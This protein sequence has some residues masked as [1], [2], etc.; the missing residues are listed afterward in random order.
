VEI[1]YWLFEDANVPM[2]MVRTLSVKLAIVIGDS[3][4]QL[5][6]WWGGTFNP[7][8]LSFEMAMECFSCGWAPS[9]ML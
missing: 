5:L 4:L 3:S 2:G 8:S 1:W 7:C 6:L 9:P